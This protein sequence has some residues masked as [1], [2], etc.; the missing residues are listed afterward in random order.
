MEV[1]N[2][3]IAQAKLV[4]RRDAQRRRAMQ[5]LVPPGSRRVCQLL[6]RG[7]GVGRLSRAA[8]R[9]PLAKVADPTAGKRG[10]PFAPRPA[11]CAERLEE[12]S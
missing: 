10:L 4:A 12:A 5:P 11:E 6:Q 9:I 1:C 2:Q 8:V 3:S 7:Q